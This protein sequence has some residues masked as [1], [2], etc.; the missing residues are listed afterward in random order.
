MSF[1]PAAASLG[2]LAL[3]AQGVSLWRPKETQKVIEQ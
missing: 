3:G 1:E 2:M